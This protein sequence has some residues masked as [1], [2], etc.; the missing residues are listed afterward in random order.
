MRLRSRGAGLPQG[1]ASG[2][3]QQTLA[4]EGEVFEVQ[5][6]PSGEKLVALTQKRRAIVWSA[7][8]GEELL[9]VNLHRRHRVRASGGGGTLSPSLALRR[10]RAALGAGSELEGGR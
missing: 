8:S 4:A 3:A 1:V 7:A 2:A 5:V 10:R 6:F 9:Q